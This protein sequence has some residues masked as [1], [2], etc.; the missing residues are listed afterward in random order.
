MKNA[1]VSW[2][3]GKDS[4]FAAMQAQ[5]AGYTVKGFLNI[6]NEE[7]LI[8]RSHGIPSQILQAQA[9]AA[10]LPIYLTAASWAD[11]EQKFTDALQT[12]KREW[13]ISHVIFGDIALQE[14]RNWEE[15][16]CNKVDVTAVLPLWQQPRK[17]LVLQMLED[18]M[19]TLVVSCNTA[20]G[21]H[22]LGRYLTPRFIAE[23]ET[24]GIDPCGEAGEFH[25]LVTGCK[26]FQNPFKVNFTGRQL[27]NDYWFASLEL[28]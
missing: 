28:A 26:M 22:F 24:V 7:G 17:Q 25:T 20:M 13:N 27:H 18:G 3:G 1:L 11:Y 6:L 16:I 10:S 9:A 15:T 4:C 23:L 12:A 19:E 5:Q 14:H 2:S 8:S 21:E